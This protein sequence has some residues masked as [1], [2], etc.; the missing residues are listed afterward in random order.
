MTILLTVCAIA[1]AALASLLV[2]TLTYA[3]RDFSRPRLEEYLQAR[4]GAEWYERTIAVHQDLIFVTATV[5]LLANIFVLLGVLHLLTY[6][7]IP[8]WV[9]YML[10]VA[11]S[12]MLMLFCSVAIPHA[13][14]QHAGE[15]LIGSHVRFLHVLR[16]AL[17]PV[18]R[19]M[20]WIDR[21]VRRALGI[22]RSESPAAAG[23]D[24]QQEILSVVEEGTK[25]GVVDEQEK[26]MIESVIQFRDTNVGQV[27]TARTD[28][29]ALPIGSSLDQ[30]KRVLEESG[31]SRIPV[32][33]GTLDHIVGILYA[34]DLLKHL[35]LP[36]DKFDVRSA[37]RPAFYVPETKPL[38][39][40]LADFRLQKV[41]LAIV[42]DE[43]G[44]TGGLV[45]ID[46]VLEEV[47]GD[48][49]DE[50][51]GTDQAMI[52]RLDEHTFD[53]DARV[54]LDELN[55][56][57]H[58]NLPEDAGY[59]TLGGFVSNT[60]GRIPSAGTRFDHAGTRF[61]IVEAEPQKVNRVKIELVPQPTDE[62]TT[63]AVA[64]PA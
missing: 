36:P 28:I 53:A 37:I 18:T 20:H 34:R 33:E 16:V 62:Q 59:E 27:M 64:R 61:T 51:E 45:T 58:L 6:W 25:E 60:L 39:D 40:L 41:H 26:Q 17:H 14:A 54:R 3:L 1:A 2:S 44:G 50:H 47:F 49:S 8:R 46:D 21:T 5:R 31:H 55:R 35:G 38:R 30:V 24:L 7:Q 15:K 29:V 48:I 42:L 19:L 22:T 4:G 11:T 52:K 43:Y 23:H 12:G 32:Y 10:A 9:Q 56:N 57:L 13:L 63:H